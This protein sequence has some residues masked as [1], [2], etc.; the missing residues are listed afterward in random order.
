MEDI[1]ILRKMSLFRDFDS[2]ELVQVSK[3]VKHVPFS[4]GDVVVRENSEGQSLFVVKEGKLHAFHEENGQRKELANFEPLS[5]FGELALIDHGPRSASVEALEDGELL[6]FDD[7]AL[8]TLIK[9]NEHLK[10]KLYMNL[11]D[12]LARKLRRTNDRLIKLL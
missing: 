6:E 8:E 2:L 3:L 10:L 11:T 5:F 7:K 12:D 4:S 1:A 9:H